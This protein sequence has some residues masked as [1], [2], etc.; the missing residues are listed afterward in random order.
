MAEQVHDIFNKKNRQRTQEEVELLIFSILDKE[1]A[2]NV[3]QVEKIIE[4]ATYAP[5]AFNRMEW[6]FYVAETPL[7]DMVKGDA[8]NPSMFATAPVRIFLA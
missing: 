7:A 2:V 3:E 6:R 1:Y 5:T 4:A 8:S